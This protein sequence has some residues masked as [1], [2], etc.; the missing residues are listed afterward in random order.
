MAN[1]TIQQAIPQSTGSFLSSSTSLI[2]GVAGE[3]SLPA[4]SLRDYVFLVI[5]VLRE[6][7]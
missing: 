4:T 1:L 5:T 2:A 7:G 6:L 3:E